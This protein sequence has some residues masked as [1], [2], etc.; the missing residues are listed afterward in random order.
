MPSLAPAAG[1]DL[2]AYA[3]A[4]LDRFRNPAIRHR[5][6]Q[7]AWDGSQKLPYR[8]LDTTDAARAAGR[9]VARLAVPVAA[10]WALIRRL[11]RARPGLGPPRPPP[12]PDTRPHP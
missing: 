12:P 3:G 7:I 8:L 4:V 11:A 6:S 1:L 2:S 10:W 5:L 9:P